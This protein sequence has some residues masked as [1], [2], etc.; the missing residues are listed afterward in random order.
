[1]YARKAFLKVVIALFV[2]FLISCGAS[3]PSAVSSTAPTAVPPT[4]APPTA[5]LPTATPAPIMP[6][7]GITL[8]GTIDASPDVNGAMISLEIATDGKAISK[9]GVL[10]RGP[11][12]C[13]GMTME[14]GS[15]MDSF[16]SGPFPINNGTFTASLWEG[17]E[18]KGQF[19]SPSTATGTITV[20]GLPYVATCQFGPANW[21]AK[22]S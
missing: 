9:I 8:T 14:E 10:L 18:I 4:V 13:G 2:L 17:G 20:K 1:M 16:I 15:K 22:E 7:S 19:D 3:S 12:K 5:V 6:R 21:S 11:T